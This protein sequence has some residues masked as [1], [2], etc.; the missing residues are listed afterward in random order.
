MPLDNVKIVYEEEGN[1]KEKVSDADGSIKLEG[2]N[3]VEF[4]FRATREAYN[5]NTVSYST[6]DCDNEASRLEIPMSRPIVN[7]SVDEKNNPSLTTSV[8]PNIQ[9]GYAGETTSQGMQGNMAGNN[10]GVNGG[11]ISG[12]TCIIRG[13]VMTQGTKKPVDGVLITLR[14][15]CDGATQTAYTDATGNYEFTVVEGCDYT[16]EG[17]KDNLGSKGKRVRKLNCKKG[18]VTADVY[19]FGTG[20]IVQIDNIYFDY[21]RCDI[22]SDARLELDK[23]VNMM[24]KYPKMRVELRSHTDSRSESD[25]NQ[26]LSDGRAKASANYLFKRGISRSRVEFS[27]Y[28]ETMLVNGCS[29]GV[30]CTEEQHAL[31]RRTEIK[32][33]Q[34]N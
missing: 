7:R 26:K 19:M 31:N 30:E 28:G 3:N 1:L 15:E 21:S 14:S 22:R 12:N 13:R 34:M 20:D 25:F 6:K 2:L 23:L 18:P 11:V 5:A 17:S 16:V 9:N 32:I 33:L 27:G 10:T 8:F 29:D 24:R 4:A